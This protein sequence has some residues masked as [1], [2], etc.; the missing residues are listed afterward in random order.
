[1]NFFRFLRGEAFSQTR[2]VTPGQQSDFYRM[3]DI[4]KKKISELFSQLDFQDPKTKFLLEQS[5][6]IFEKSYF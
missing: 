1:M 4:L 5:K 6:Q 2:P 3:E